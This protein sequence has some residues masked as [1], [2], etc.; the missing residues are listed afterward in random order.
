MSLPEHHARRYVTPL[1][2]GGSLP[3]IVDTDAGLWVVK[4]VGAGQ[5]AR[6]LIA[7]ILVGEIARAIGL[8]VPELALIE[9]DASFGRTEGDPEIQDLLKAS[10]GLNVGMRYLDGALN[11]DPVAA[12]DVVDP[13]TAADIVWLDAFTTNIDRTPRNPNMMVSDDR[14][15]LIDHGA[16]L[17]FHHAWQN[18]SDA[19]V[20]RPFDAIEH[21]VLLPTAGSISDAHDRA[22]LQ[23]TRDELERIATLVP[24]ELLMHAPHRAPPFATAAENRAAYVDVL[25]KRLESR[26]FV[27]QADASRSQT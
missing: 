18:V 10:V 19:S 8:R 14:L 13:T 3:A 24:D 20:V 22:Q 7:E 25:T 23:L 17:Y 6:A 5:G 4:F 12:A 16:A 9:L 11:F 21:H 2:E 26:A 27:D 1:K 15:W